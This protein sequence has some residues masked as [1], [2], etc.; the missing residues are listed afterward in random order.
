MHRKKEEITSISYINVAAKAGD[1]PNGI[2]KCDLERFS[3]L[4]WDSV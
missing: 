1:S 2:P 3:D 4:L